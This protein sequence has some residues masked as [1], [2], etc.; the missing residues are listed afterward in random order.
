M[1]VCMWVCVPFALLWGSNDL[2]PLFSFSFFFSSHNLRLFCIPLSPTSPLD[3]NRH[4]RDQEHLS[5]DTHSLSHPRTHTTTNTHTRTLHTH[6]THIHTLHN[7]G[8]KEDPNQ[9]HYRRAQPTGNSITLYSLTRTLAHTARISPWSLDVCPLSNISP[10]FNW[11][12]YPTSR[13]LPPPSPRTSRLQTSQKKVV[14]PD[15]SHGSNN[16]HRQSRFLLL[17]PFCFPFSSEQHPP[18]RF[19]LVGCS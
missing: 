16:I 13:R 19:Q 9:N 1:C 3:K 6:L 2:I 10:S 7:H 17:C 15:N 8:T 18:V 11:R 4:S 5:F 12:S 14:S